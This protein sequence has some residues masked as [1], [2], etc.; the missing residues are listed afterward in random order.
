M[1]LIKGKSQKTFVKNLKTELN[2]GKP[3]KQSLAIAYA[4]KRKGKAKGGEVKKKDKDFEK[5][6]KEHQSRFPSEHA[7]GVHAESYNHPESTS[8]AGETYR[9]AKYYDPKRKA[10]GHVMAEHKSKLDELKKIKPKLKGL[11]EGGTVEDAQESM[12]K[13]F[14]YAD[15]GEVMKPKRKSL[16]ESASDFFARAQNEKPDTKD[17]KYARVREQNRKEVE[18]YSHGGDISPR[19]TPPK[20]LLDLNSDRDIQVLEEY[21]LYPTQFNKSH[22]AH[23]SGAMHED[24]K[25]LNQHYPDM[26]ASTD[27]HEEDMVDR[28]MNKKS[29]DFSSLAR[30][31]HGGPVD[32]SGGDGPYMDDEDDIVNRIMHKASPSFSG[33]DRLSRGGQIANQ[34]H[35]ENNNEMAGFSPNEFDDLVL[36]D[37]LES[38][39][40]DDDN[41]GDDLGNEQEDE[42]R[43]DIVARIMRSQRKKDRL[44]NPA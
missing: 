5:K 42:D 27:M 18:G 12:R 9:S 40:G 36:R 19:V 22:V 39:Y 21:E 26:H 25:R 10:Y 1:P 44:P 43:K 37:D 15:G 33:L 17:D 31:A 34:E 11:A 13:A 29:K 32:A 2:E 20:E 28:I 3:M 35:G 6:H 16:A 8:Q 38:H 23:N 41:S 24:S 7:K 4:M 14:K 30:L